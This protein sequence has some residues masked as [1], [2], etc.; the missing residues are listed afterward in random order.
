MLN[1]TLDVPIHLHMSTWYD[2]LKTLLCAP[3]LVASKSTLEELFPLGFA[4]MLFGYRC[5]G[6]S[7]LGREYYKI[8]VDSFS[9]V[10]G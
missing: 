4:R 3:A 5:Y 1:R 10:K 9:P 7:T 6:N 2:D 8:S